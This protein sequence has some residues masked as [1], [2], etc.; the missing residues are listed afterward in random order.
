MYFVCLFVCWLTVEWVRAHRLTSAQD[1]GKKRKELNDSDVDARS[2]TL[3]GLLPCTYHCA[4]RFSWAKVN[5]TIRQDYVYKPNN[6]EIRKESPSQLEST[7]LNAWQ[8]DS[9][10]VKA[11]FKVENPACSSVPRGYGL[12]NLLLNQPTIT[13]H[14]ALLVLLPLLLFQIKGKR[15]KEGNAL[16]ARHWSN[17]PLNIFLFVHMP[18]SYS[19]IRWII[20]VW[21]LWK[22][23]LVIVIRQHW[24]RWALLKL[25]RKEVVL[26]QGRRWRQWRWRLRRTWGF[27]TSFMG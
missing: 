26:S 4:R 21:S 23:S 10:A 11:S 19:L 3:V 15:K 2:R 5:S 6:K 22:V 13:G 16:Q 8:F 9:T 24:N 17:G 27:I 14:H 18:Y 25:P 12:R 1:R 7:R 20:L